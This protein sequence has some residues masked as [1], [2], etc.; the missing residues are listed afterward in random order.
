MAIERAK[1]CSG[2]GRK[3]RTRETCCCKRRS[4]V[5]FLNDT[6]NDNACYAGPILSSISVRI[7]P[8]IWKHSS[9][10]H[11]HSYCINIFR[12]PG[13]GCKLFT[14]IIHRRNPCTASSWLLACLARLGY[15]PRS[16]RIA[17]PRRT[18]PTTSCAQR[19]YCEWHNSKLGNQCITSS[20]CPDE[21]TSDGFEFLGGKGKSC[22]G[23][24][25][26]YEYE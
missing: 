18:A 23:C 12:N 7:Y 22:C 26:Y 1:K 19:V 20:E 3:N 2:R 14:V 17:T 24:C 5:A 11:S 8:S 16:S 4:N 6:A 15:H 10:S 13:S 25:K 21:W 9:Y